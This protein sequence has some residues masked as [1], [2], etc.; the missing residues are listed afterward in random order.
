MSSTPRRDLQPRHRSTRSWLADHGA[1]VAPALAFA[2]VSHQLWNQTYF[3]RLDF[4]IYMEAVTSWSRSSIYD[5]AEVHTHLGFTYPPFAGVVLWPLAHLDVHLAEH[6]WMIASL[7]ASLAFLV[8]AGRAL[9]SP[10]RWR[11]F[12]PAFVAVGLL[13][14]PVVLTTRIGQINSFLALIVLVDCLGARR[15]RRFTGVGVGLA[16]AVKLTPMVGV[17]YFAVARRGRAIVTA[18]AT[19]VGATLVA[20]VLHPSDSKSYWTDVLFDTSRVG[21]LDSKLSNSLRRALTWL[22]VGNGMQSILWVGLC[23][24][25]IGV[26]VW[27]ARVAYDRGND[28]GAVTVIMC[29]GLLCSPITWSHHL[30]FLILAVPLLIGDGRSV[31]RWVAAAA[32]LPLMLEW[33]DQGQN[34]SQSALRVLLLLLVVVALPLD[35]NE[36]GAV[37]STDEPTEP[38]VPAPT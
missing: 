19:L 14:T 36:T 23:L 29:A 12:V 1:W 7:L 15:G 27:R 3:Q 22:P 24:V 10:P 20:W 33:H 26:A 18:V 5:Y 9:P 35:R 30:Y 28:L 31:T 8:I 37:T 16:A 13:S 2:F 11:W 32:T 6:L 34:P 21:S 4:H 38:L 17:L 25:I